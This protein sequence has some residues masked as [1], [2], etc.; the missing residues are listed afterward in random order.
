VMDH[1]QHVMEAG[2]PD[3]HSPDR[4]EEIR[5][6]NRYY[7]QRLGTL[8]ESLLD[9]SLSLTQARVLWEL[10]QG[11]G[12]SAVDL[13]RRLDLDASYLSRIIGDFA[14]RGW[15]V[16]TPSADD[17]RKSTLAMTGAGRKVFA[18]LNEASR[19]QLE[20]WLKPLPET[21]RDQLVAA[22]QAVMALL[23][24]RDAKKSPL[25]VIRA[26]RPGDMGWVIEAQARL[27]AEEYGWNQEFE[28]LVAEICARFLRRFDAEREHCWIAESGG[29]RVGSVTLVAK[30]KTTAQLRMLFVTP[31][32]RGLGLGRKLLEE[33][34]AFARRSGYRKMILWTNDCLHAARKLYEDAGFRLSKSE[35]HHS[36]GHDLV[37]QFWERSL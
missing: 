22:M 1:V 32:A 37:G 12:T 25:A 20:D 4:I 5:R 19:R 6:F 27:Y 33:S 8:N 30:S 24:G 29:H 13:C 14:E 11:E 21:D 16:R 7:T 9:S 26:H 10:A 31:E 23:E 18:P 17:A 35:A 36:F 2:M 34:L 3:S 15:V 28:A